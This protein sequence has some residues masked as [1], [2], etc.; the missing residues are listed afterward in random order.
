MTDSTTPQE[1]DA[2]IAQLAEQLARLQARLERVEA[3]EQPEAQDG[4][5]AP[6]AG[7]G[8]MVEAARTRAGAAW[9]AMT[10]PAPRE[11]GAAPQSGLPAVPARRS[12]LGILGLLVA[13]LLAAWIAAEIA[14]EIVKV[15]RRLL[16]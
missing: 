8:A 14:E 12:T 1:A 11:P 10:A 4:G 3:R 13:A 2:A 9:A 7:L 5:A 6:V 15:L 16:R